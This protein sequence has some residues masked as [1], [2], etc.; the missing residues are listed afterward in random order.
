MAIDRV[1]GKRV[2]KVKT[3]ED[4]KQEKKEK[5]LPKFD[6]TYEE[7]LIKQ[8]FEEDSKKQVVLETVDTVEE[9]AK[10]HHARPGEE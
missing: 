2:R 4:V 10:V 3:K 1:T 5:A 7:E 8:L 6:V 9:T